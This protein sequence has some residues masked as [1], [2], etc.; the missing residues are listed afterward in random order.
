MARYVA[1]LEGPSTAQSRVVISIGEPALVA[2][3]MRVISR[4]FDC[5]KDPSVPPPGGKIIPFPSTRL[6]PRSAS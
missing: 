4:S 2:E 3:I 6:S 1:I 5:S